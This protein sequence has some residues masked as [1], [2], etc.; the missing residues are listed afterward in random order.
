MT[1]NG[2][3]T[4]PKETLWKLK[5]SNRGWGKIK[6]VWKR[7]LGNLS[8]TAK[9]TIHDWKNL[10]LRRVVPSKDGGKDNVTNL[11][12]LHKECPGG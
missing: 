7:Q 6:S 1:P 2:K 8:P 9:Y 12:L 10:N 11:I 4:S 3:N 5:Q